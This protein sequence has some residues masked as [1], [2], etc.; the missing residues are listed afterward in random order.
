[1]LNTLAWCLIIESIISKL[2]VMLSH[3]TYILNTFLL[4]LSIIWI[5]SCLKRQFCNGVY[6]RT[7]G[8]SANTPMSQTKAILNIRVDMSTL[9]IFWMILERSLMLSSDLEILINWVSYTE[10]RVFWVAWFGRRSWIIVLINIR[11]ECP[12][13]WLLSGL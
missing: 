12:V 9:I 1:M 5:F 6:H 8:R 10:M 3:D 11:G 7:S 4:A 2:I 13:V